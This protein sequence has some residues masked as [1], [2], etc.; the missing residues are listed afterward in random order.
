LTASISGPVWRKVNS[1]RNSS[2]GVDLDKLDWSNWWTD[3]LHGVHYLKVKEPRW[4]TVQRVYCKHSNA[5][6]VGVRNGTL[7][8]L[9]DIPKTVSG[10][11]EGEE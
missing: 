10:S 5:P 7:C 8:W 3:S 6:R 1:P 4:G 11:S 9:I 2:C